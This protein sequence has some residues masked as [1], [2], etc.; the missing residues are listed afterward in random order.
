MKNILL[1]HWAGDMDELTRL[2]VSNIS[3][4]AKH[5]DAE[6]R[7]LEGMLFNPK[8]SPQCQKLFMLDPLFD[9]YDMVVMVDADM[10]TR[11]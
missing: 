6:Y 11:K 3:K 5:C 1:Q 10:F 9:E 8:L 7:L 2:S 4:Y